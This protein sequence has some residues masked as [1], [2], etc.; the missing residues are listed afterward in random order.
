MSMVPREQLL[1]GFVT[2]IQYALVC[3][4][5]TEQLDVEVIQARAE[6]ADVDF[7]ANCCREA[8]QRA[9]SMEY[10]LPLSF[11]SF[12][13]LFHCELDDYKWQPQQ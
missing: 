7:D 11:F 6:A 13:T 2:Q 3:R 4:H 10:N 9:V 1:R 5:S 12:R 8:Y